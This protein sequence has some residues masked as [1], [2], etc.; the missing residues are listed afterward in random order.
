[1]RFNEPNN[2]KEYFI[3]IGLKLTDVCLS[4]KTMG[5]IGTISV[6]TWLVVNKYITGDN[7]VSFVV[8]IFVCIYGIREAYKV[9][10]MWHS[11]KEKGITKAVEDVVAGA[12]SSSEQEK[13]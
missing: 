5:L 10:T 7:F 9:G 6:G 2:I 1:M 8:P 11:I 4:V 3:R 12:T 13:K